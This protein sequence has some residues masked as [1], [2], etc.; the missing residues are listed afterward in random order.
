MAFIRT[1]EVPYKSQITKAP[2]QEPESLSNF[3]TSVRLRLLL[4]Y[5]HHMKLALQE[6]NMEPSVMK[7]YV[8]DRMIDAILLGSSS[9]RIQGTTNLHIIHNIKLWVCFSSFFSYNLLHC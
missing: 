4:H 2:I 6:G 3:G 9:E 5:M 7:K 1:Q 8:F